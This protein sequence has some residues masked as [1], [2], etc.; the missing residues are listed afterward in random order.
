MKIS[1]S[2][3]AAVNAQKQRRYAA[4]EAA[5]V[6]V[7]A[8]DIAPVRA[9]AQALLQWLLENWQLCLIIAAFLAMITLL[10]ALGAKLTKALRSRGNHGGA[11]TPRHGGDVNVGAP[12]AQ[13][14]QLPLPVPP[15]INTGLRAGTVNFAQQTQHQPHQQRESQ[16]APRQREALASQAPSG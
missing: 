13:H 16:P 15:P 3:V 11:N 14:E 1:D 8:A 12:P 2:F 6:T 10:Y 4:Q 9:Q 5:A 7:G